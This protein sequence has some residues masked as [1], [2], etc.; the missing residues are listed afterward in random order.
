MGNVGSY[1][2]VLEYVILINNFIKRRIFMKKL[3]S[4]FMV[5]ALVLGVLFYTPTSVVKADTETFNL[6]HEYTLT[7][8]G[9][10]GYNKEHIVG[11]F[12][13]QQGKIYKIVY[14][15]NTTV[16]DGRYKIVIKNAL[17][18][19]VIDTDFSNSG[20]TAVFSFTKGVLYCVYSDTLSVG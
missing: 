15:V 12:A 17:Y 5:V 11:Q 19:T 9:Q 10:D 20:E 2:N 7:H 8:Q 4:G 18:P 6:N 13:A 3:L 14:N 16:K 1:W